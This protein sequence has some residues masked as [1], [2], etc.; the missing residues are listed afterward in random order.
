MN[1]CESSH[2]PK[3]QSAQFEPLTGDGEVEMS[4]RSGASFKGQVQGHRKKGCGI[5]TWANGDR[6]EG[7]FEDN[8]REGQG[9]LRNV[10]VCYAG[11]NMDSWMMA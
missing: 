2:F 10:H 1:V 5:F 11:S 9:I 6:Y 8:D 3:L 7:D 4:Y